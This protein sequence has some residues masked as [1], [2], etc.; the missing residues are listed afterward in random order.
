MQ[1]NKY[2][3]Y[4]MANA[5]VWDRLFKNYLKPHYD[6]RRATSGPD[7]NGM[8]IIDFIIKKYADGCASYPPPS[9]SVWLNYLRKLTLTSPHLQKILTLYLCYDAKLHL[10][11]QDNHESSRATPVD[12][13][14]RPSSRS[15]EPKVHGTKMQQ[16]LENLENIPFAFDFDASIM[17]LSSGLWALDNG[18]VGAAVRSLS[19]PSIG[20]LANYFDCPQELKKMIVESLIV[21][22]QNPRMALY[23]SESLRYEN[24]DE[25]YEPLFAS[26]LLTSGQISEALKYQR[27]FADQPNYEE[28]LKS[29][30]EISCESGTIK[31]LNRLNLNPEEEDMINQY[32][33]FLSSQSET[34]RPTTPCNVQ[35]VSKHV[36]FAESPVTV[37]VAAATPPTPVPIVVAPVTPVAAPKSKIKQSSSISTP[38]AS[39]STLMRPK[40]ATTPSPTKTASPP[41]KAATVTITEPTPTPKATRSKPST[42]SSSAR[43]RPRSRNLDVFKK[44]PSFSDSPARNTRSAKKNKNIK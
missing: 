12:D 13:T 16:S 43:G 21:M 29:F 39:K 27:T 7:R 5:K 20:N 36:T 30:F 10:G 18:E 31:L 11:H 25:S 35:I 15:P 9:T 26:L 6:K 38:S 4:V 3:E 19:N 37:T 17:H 23:V 42:S 8:L 32:R 14:S 24:W 28:I 22:N 40:P 2:L 44:Q 34:S 33:D 1:L 41:A